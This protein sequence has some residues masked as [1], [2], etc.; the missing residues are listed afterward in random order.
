MIRVLSLGAGVQ[1][2]AVLLMSCR[3]ILPKLD[4]A[5][6]ADTQWE[7]SEVYEHLEWLTAEA[8]KYGIPVHIVTAG[9]I[10]GDLFLH[11]SLIPLDMVDLKPGNNGAGMSE[12]CLGMCGV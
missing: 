5:I 4:H 11:R 7:P 6:F 2:T 10:V 9:K 3:G 8:A 12:E 1:S